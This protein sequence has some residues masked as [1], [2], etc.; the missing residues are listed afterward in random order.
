MWGSQTK[1]ILLLP[2][3]IYVEGSDLAI[4]NPLADGSLTEIEHLPIFS[5]MKTLGLMTHPT[6]SSAAAL[7]PTQQQGQE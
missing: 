2:N 5:P 4:G 3:I 1:H 7:G 6:G